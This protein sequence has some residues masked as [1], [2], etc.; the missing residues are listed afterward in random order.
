MPFRVRDFRV[1]HPTWREES[2]PAGEFVLLTRYLSLLNGG[3]SLLLKG[4]TGVLFSERSKGWV[5]VQRH[6]CFW[7]L[8]CTGSFKGP[9]HDLTC[10]CMGRASWSP[11]F[12]SVSLSTSSSHF[13]PWV[14]ELWRSYSYF[15]A[16]LPFRWIFIFFLTLSIIPKFQK[17]QMGKL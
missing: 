9:G 10:F 3:H 13:S 16:S 1:Y 2:V 6:V 14:R 4:A 11:L 15:K 5:K 8:S 12:E 17:D 7:C